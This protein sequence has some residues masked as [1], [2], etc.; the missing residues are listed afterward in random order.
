LGICLV[1]IQPPSYGLTW[2][3]IVDGICLILKI[4][5]YIIESHILYNFVRS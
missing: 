2:D 5:E 4:Y 1:G 3:I